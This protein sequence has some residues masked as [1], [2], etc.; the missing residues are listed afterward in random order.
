[1]STMNWVKAKKYYEI[2]GD[3]HDAVHARRKRGQWVDGIHCRIVAGSLWIDL[4]QV[5]E[6]IENPNT[7]TSPGA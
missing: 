7:T 4:E 2:T 3:T 5:Q 6:W 1:M